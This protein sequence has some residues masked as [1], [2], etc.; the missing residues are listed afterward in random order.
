MSDQNKI[1]NHDPTQAAKLTNLISSITAVRD[2]TTQAAAS[3]ESP[4]FKMDSTSPLSSPNSKN[5]MDS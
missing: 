2:L 1:R 4:F 5:G 3:A